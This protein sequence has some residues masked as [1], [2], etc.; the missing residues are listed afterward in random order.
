LDK[1]GHRCRKNIRIFG[2]IAALMAFLTLPQANVQAMPFNPLVNYAVGDGPYSVTVGDFDGDLNLDLAV[3]NSSANNVSILLGNGDG[4]FDPAVDYG[5]GSV[6]LSLAVGDFDGDLN[7]DLAVANY[8]DNNISILLGNG[9]GTFDPAVNYDV[10][11]GP[12][13][14]AVGD[15]DGDINLDL[16]AVNYNVNNVSILLGNGDGTFDSAVNYTVG[17]NPI[18]VAVGDFDGDLNLDL[19]V[20]NSTDNNVSILL[21]NGDG[22]FD[23]AVNYGVGDN[24]SSVAV[25]DFDGDLNLDVAVADYNINKVSVL[26]GNGDGTFQPAVNY[27]VGDSP[28]SIAVDELNGDGRLDLA[29]VDYGINKVSI[30]LGNGDGTFNVAVNY[31]VDSS[32]LSVAVGELNGDSRPDLAVVDYGVDS[33]SILLN[34]SASPPT[35]FSAATDVTGATITVTFSKNMLDPAGKQAEFS[36]RIG[37]GSAQSFSAAALNLDNTK[38]DLT[39]SGTPI[40]YGDAVTVSYTKGTVLAADG[41]VLD[42]FTN[43]PVTNNVPATP[44]TFVSAATNITGTIITITF[45]KNMASPFGKQTEFSYRIG[46]GSAQ[47]FSAAA[48]N[49]D[50]TKIDLT[51]SGTPIAYGD[52]V[53]VSY[54]KG[55]VLAA[56]GGVLESFTDQPV[57]NN[58]PGPPLFVSAATDIAGSTITITFSKNMANPFGKQAEFSYRI[59][60]GSAQSFSAAALNVNNTKIDLTCSGTPI[61]YGDAV[62]VSYTKGTVLA[63]DGGVLE[64]FTDQPVTNNMIQPPLFVSAVTDIAGTTITTTFSKNMADPFGKQ[65]EFSYKV[66]GGLGQSFSAAVLNPDNTKIDL[67][68]SGAAIVFND[69]VTV[70]YTKGTVLAADGGVLASFTDQPVTNNLPQSSQQ[71]STATGTGTATFTTSDGSITGLTASLNVICGPLLGYVFPHGF[72]SFN[73]IN[74]TPGSTVVITITLPTDMSTGT[75]YWKCINGQWLDCSSLLGDDDG[76]NILTLTITDGGLGDADGTA[77]GTII[78]PGGPALALAVVPSVPSVPR[79]SSLPTGWLKPAQISLKYLNVN[80]QQAS[81]NQQVTIITNVVNIGNEP[82]NYSIDLKINGQVEQT[83]TVSVGPQATQPVKFTVV[84]AQPGTYDID[85]GGLKGSFTVLGASGYSSP[86]NSGWIALIVIVVLLPSTVVLVLTFRRAAQKRKSTR[87]IIS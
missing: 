32:P 38:I 75:R 53:T 35:F 33:V 60:P 55:T 57:S 62:T 70:S 10:V 45:D 61:A 56:D 27:D 13:S 4:T 72:F 11:N 5:A 16:A 42:S 19:A 54:T 63:A 40:A 73:I 51:C 12:Y 15:F 31:D 26:L 37:P 8:S 52:A 79:S 59:G 84:K 74:I 34:S 2:A 24:P 9:D 18:S 49:L 76:D 48:L 65:A 50:N 66:N 44:P 78:D 7:L 23:P 77:N 29:V 46:P 83:K 1:L 6:P 64:S 30:L 67:T 80:P 86:L 85:I 68:C 28:T 21:G 25:G 47:S 43:Q 20:T 81:A 82:G 22:T 14:V 69:I 17:N 71:V 3:A 87:E 39:C 41:N 36:Y 58:I